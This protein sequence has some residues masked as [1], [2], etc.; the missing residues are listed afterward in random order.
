MEIFAQS[1]NENEYFEQK[2]IYIN[3]QLNKVDN[4]LNILKGKL[5]FEQ[6]N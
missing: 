4:E 1:E 5:E 2:E 6:K 3:N